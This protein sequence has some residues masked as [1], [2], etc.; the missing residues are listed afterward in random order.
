M[1]NGK[2]NTRWRAD[3]K[4][5]AVWDGGCIAF[6]KGEGNKMEDYVCGGRAGRKL[7]EDREDTMCRRNVHRQEIRACVGGDVTWR[8]R[9]F[10][11]AGGRIAGEAGCKRDGGGGLGTS[12]TYRLLWG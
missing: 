1:L 12:E 10:Q 9:M 4:K 3:K 5:R 7:E 2:Q 8:A 6:R 11:G